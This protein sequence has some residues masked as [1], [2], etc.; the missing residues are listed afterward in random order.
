MA[1]VGLV[2]MAPLSARYVSVDHFDQLGL[3][4]SLSSYCWLER[5]AP[6]TVIFVDLYSTTVYILAFLQTFRP[7]TLLFASSVFN[8]QLSFFN[9]SFPFFIRSSSKVSLFLSFSYSCILHASCLTVRSSAI[10]SIW[11]IRSNLPALITL[12]IYGSL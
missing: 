1:D 11:L 7:R 12:S 9:L 2:R 4:Y 10:L 5:I 6:K 8:L 3:V